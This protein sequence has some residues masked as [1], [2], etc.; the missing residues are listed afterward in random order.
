M[1]ILIL[2][3]RFMAGPASSRL[4]WLE[5]FEGPKPIPAW[6]AA[7]MGMVNDMGRL[8][9][10]RVFGSSGERWRLRESSLSLRRFDQKHHGGTAGNMFSFMEDCEILRLITTEIAPE[11]PTLLTNVDKWFDPKRK[12]GGLWFPR[13]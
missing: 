4:E 9:C 2:T 12:F 6:Q 10:G 8:G 7:M 5:W 11:I 3:C 1:G 13:R